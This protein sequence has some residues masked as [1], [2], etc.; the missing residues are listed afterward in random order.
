LNLQA[1]KSELYRMNL[2]RFIHDRKANVFLALILIL[3]FAYLAVKYIFPGT[4]PLVSILSFITNPVLLLVEKFSNIILRW[5][6]SPLTIQNHSVLLNGS[7]I[8]GFT[9]QIMYKKVTFFYIL[10]LWLTR[11]STMRKICFTGIYVVVSFLAASFYNVA[12]AYLIAGDSIPSIISNTHSIVFF[13]M[14]TAL[15]FWYLIN[16]KSW[17]ANPS[18]ISG[19]VDLLERKLPDIIKIIYVYIIVLFSLGYFDFSLLIDF[20]LGSSQRIVGLLGYYAVVKDTLLIGDN[21]SISMYRTCLGIMTMF[22]FAALVYLTGS[23]N[24]RGWGF[25]IIGLFILNLANI[26]RI[27]LVFIHLQKHGDYLLAMDIHDLYNYATYF[28]VFIL[29]V[30]WFEKYMDRKTIKS[31]RSFHKI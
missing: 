2:K 10:L 24:K 15:L 17:S 20:I 30:I 6:E 11:A 23:K 8:D 18:G 31:I 3:L 28:I 25:I 19:F 12:G 26:A 22:L 7:Q 16:K 29:W 27:V 13:C 1:G 5:I 14:N 21:G 4:D 9:T